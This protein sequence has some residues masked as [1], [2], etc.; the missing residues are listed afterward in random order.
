MIHVSWTL[1][2]AMAGLVLAWVVD[3]ATVREVVGMING[4]GRIAPVSFSGPRYL[5]KPE[6][7]K[8]MELFL[9]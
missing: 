5:F 1:F 8:K 3:L 6:N 9:F 2:V 7:Q 4:M